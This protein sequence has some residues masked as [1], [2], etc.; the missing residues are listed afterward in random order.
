MTALPRDPEQ[1]AHLIEQILS[2]TGVFCRV[3][4]G[5]D[6]DRDQH[7]NC[8]SEIG[9]GGVRNYG[10][11]QEVIDFLD[12]WSKQHPFKQLECPR[13]A[14]KSSMVK[15]LILR[16]ILAFPN[17]AILLVMAS[18]KDAEDRIAEIKRDLEENP[19]IQELFPG[20][21]CDGSKYSFTTSLRSDRT[22][23]SP[24]LMGA[25]PQKIPVG[26][27]FNL[28]VGDDV[29]DDNNTRTAEGLEKG[30][31]TMQRCLFLRARDTIVLNVGTPRDDGDLN[32]WI[33]DQPG[34]KKCTH[35][36][37][38]FDVV[39][40]DDKTLDLEGEPR[41]ENLGRDFLLSQLRGGVPYSEFMAQY[42]LRVVTSLSAAFKREQ[43]QG[44]NF[45]EEEHSRL[46]GY[47]L[48]DVATSLDADACLNV[49]ME[50]GI[51][52]RRH[53]FILDLEVGRWT[54]H[55]FVHRML[56]MRA[57]W[58]G[59]V[60]HQA[61]LMETTHATGGYASMLGISAGQRGE[62]LNLV[63]VKRNAASKSKDI[64]ILNCQGLFQ[65]R[66]VHV[67]NALSGRK[68]MYDADE[69]LLWDPQGF[70]D[71]TE[72]TKLPA[73][74]LV[75]QFVRFRPDG[76]GLKDI[77]DTF[78]MVLEQDEHG[79]P[80]CFWRRPSHLAAPADTVRRKVKNAGPQTSGYT[81][82]FYNRLA[83]RNA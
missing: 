57:R 6:T 12:D 65:G 32:A 4:L 68:W 60:N 3:V 55:E 16:A 77:P 36:D 2:D 18:K 49:L 31:Q 73:G 40:R 9:K 74:D 46:T 11:H 25:S 70:N 1:R 29:A 34:W 54:M 27:R 47:L 78:A 19:I 33:K 14:Y 52:H 48:T 15:G 56:N 53:I 39:E 13:Y 8:T 35:L 23:L 69:R 37:I 59:R 41:W 58:S 7:G 45:K 26:G 75:E 44:F 66:E 20:L 51:D 5:M 30:I 17:I 80:L 21:E 83:R 64:R 79:Q 50:V 22:V 71:P 38:G 28:I 43:F 61:E 72:K 67:N 62:K 24:T 42:K 10:P 81:T 76:K 82:R 63:K